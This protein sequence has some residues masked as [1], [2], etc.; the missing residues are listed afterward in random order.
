[1]ESGDNSCH[2]STTNSKCLKDFTVTPVRILKKKTGAAQA[3]KKSRHLP[4]PA[5]EGLR[6]RKKRQNAREGPS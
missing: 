3:V 6:G 1:M 2:D 4:V 5:P